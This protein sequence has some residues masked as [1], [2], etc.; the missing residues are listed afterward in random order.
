MIP[1]QRYS[2]V[3]LH[4]FVRLKYN[5]LQCFM[6]V[7]RIMPVK[8]VRGFV[9]F[10][11]NQENL[12][13]WRNEKLQYAVISGVHSD[14]RG[15]FHFFLSLASLDHCFP[16]SAINISAHLRLGRPRPL[17][18]MSLSMETWMEE[19][20]TRVL[21]VGKGRRRATCFWMARYWNTSSSQATQNTILSPVL[22]EST[23]FHNSLQKG[24]PTYVT[25]RQP[26]PPP[27]ISS[28]RSLH[29]LFASPTIS[30]EYRHKSWLRSMMTLSCDEMEDCDV[31]VL[32]LASHYADYVNM[33][34]LIKEKSWKN[35]IVLLKFAS[36]NDS[37]PTRETLVVTGNGRYIE[38]YG[39]TYNS[40]TV[41]SNIVT[42]L[43]SLETLNSVKSSSNHGDLFLIVFKSMSVV[44]PLHIGCNDSEG[45]SNNVY[46]IPRLSPNGTKDC[47]QTEEA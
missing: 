47:P 35:M 38:G 36:S 1:F 24:V 26:T 37:V 12:K 32:M 15:S 14:S 22:P 18:P 25:S 39:L 31:L 11:Q 10:P 2:T 7:D 34:P 19:A 30:G 17:F 3:S 20:N 33:S 44:R 27:R 21:G 16:A 40:R 43:S 29:S 8:F 6:D 13:R 23:F 28:L 41:I 45:T 46:G 4:V 42:Y 5:L 9:T